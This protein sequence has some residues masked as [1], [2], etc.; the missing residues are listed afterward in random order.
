MK[1]ELIDAF[2]IKNANKLKLD[3]KI[4]LRNKLLTCD[5]KAFALLMSHKKPT[6]RS[7][8]WRRW[9]CIILSYY[10]VGGWAGCSQGKVHHF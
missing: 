3:E 8:F 5:D 9:F 10:L 6:T 7:N 2:L 4:E 1:Y